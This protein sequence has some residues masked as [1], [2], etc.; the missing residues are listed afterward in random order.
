MTRV[1]FRTFG[2]LTTITR[3]HQ[4]EIEFPGTTVQDLLDALVAKFGGPMGNVLYP[5][6]GQFS[7]MLYVL[8]NGKNMTYLDGTATG[9]KDGDIVSVLPMTAGG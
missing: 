5:Q 8:V 9:L 4:M 7:E 2:H 3:G 1:L 6:G